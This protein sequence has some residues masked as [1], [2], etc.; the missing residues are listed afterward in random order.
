[1]P[2]I[3]W[4]SL[5]T[6]LDKH[7]TAKLGW[8][9]LLTDAATLAHGRLNP[10]IGAAQQADVLGTP[11]TAAMRHFFASAGPG[12]LVGKIRAPTLLIQGTV[13]DLFTLQEAVSN[14]AILRRHGVAVKML[15]FCGG[16]GICLTNPGQTALIQRD[17]IAWLDR[18]LKREPR[19]GTGPTFEWVDQR[20]G[21]HTG[22]DYLLAKGG[23][24]GGE[25]SGSLQF[26]TTGGSGPA[27]PGPSASL[28]GSFAAKVTPAKATNAVNVEVGSPRRAAL[29]VGVPQLTVAY[30]GLAT[31]GQTHTSIYAQIVDDA[32]GLVLGNQVTPVPVTLD[33]VAHTLT[34]PMSPCRS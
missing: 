26:N 31:N 15:W 19:V 30:R 4:H 33:G 20:G 16:H 21:E 12:A 9:T 8:A 17:T 7:G 22:T 5:V 29:V 3:A 23:A 34:E 32:T 11:L 1:V 10:L 18:Y 24:L 28:V 27:T 2:D 14:Y 6:S 25:A 13:D